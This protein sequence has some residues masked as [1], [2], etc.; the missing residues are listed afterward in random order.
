MILFLNIK[1]WKKSLTKRDFVC[2][3]AAWS[4]LCT[5]CMATKIL[6]ERKDRHTKKR[7][8]SIPDTLSVGPGRVV[9]WA[10]WSAWCACST[11]P[12]SRYP[13]RRS[14]SPQCKLY[15]ISYLQGRFE[16]SG[17]GEG[18]IRDLEGGGANTGFVRKQW[19]QKS[20][21]IMLILTYYSPF[22]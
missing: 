1:Y 18:H 5:M 20:Q 10:A 7:L 8:F 14:R 22:L 12:P 4:R 19:L 2:Q 9:C 17:F 15:G 3:Y 11:T 6:I 13:A 16:K 21:I